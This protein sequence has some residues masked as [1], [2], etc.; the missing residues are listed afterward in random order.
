MCWFMCFRNVVCDLFRWC[1]IVNVV[2]L[3]EIIINFFSRCVRVIVLLGIRFMCV[4]LLVMVCILLVV[5]V[6][7]LFYVCLFFL[8]YV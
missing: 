5:M 2:L 3:L 7:G 8:M 6:I 1:V 4:L